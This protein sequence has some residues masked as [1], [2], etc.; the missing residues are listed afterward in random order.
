MKLKHLLL[1]TLALTAI[2]THAQ[3]VADGF[4][5]VQNYGTKRYTYV[6]DNTGSIDISNTSADMG[7]IV[8]YKD[9]QRRLTDPAS[10]IYIAGKGKSDKYDLYDLEAQGTGVN[11]IINYYVTVTQGSVPGTYWVF[12]PT[13]GMYLVD[14]LLNNYEES[15]IDTRGGNAN[16]RCWSIYPV[17]ANTDEYLGIAPNPQLRVGNKYYKPYYF[18][19]ALNLAGTGMKAYYISAVK[20]DAVI[21]S[22]I[23]GTIPPATPVIIE[24]SS[25]DAST[26]RVTPLYTT[27]AAITGNQLSGNYFCYPDHGPT[28][29]RTYD[30]N[31]MRL[32]AVVDGRLQYITDTNHDYTTPLEF[33]TSSGVV[34]RHCIPA[35]ESYLQVPQGTAANLPVMTQAEYDALH[36]TGKPGDVNGDGTVNAIDAAMVYRAIAAGTTATQAPQYDVNGDGAINAIDAAMIYRIIAHES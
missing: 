31:T 4:Y 36:P 11:K 17:S 10:V 18:G 1:T 8:L 16:S 32:L 6:L 25:T 22:P 21:I 12:Q 13:Y 14:P 30:P 33:Y 7:A 24:C 27:P 29:Y 15:Y 23:T 35:N 34:N 19:F 9:A 26:N 3:Q 20:T 5:R 2:C 28:A